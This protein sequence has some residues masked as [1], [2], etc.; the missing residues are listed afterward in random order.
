MEKE[1]RQIGVYVEDDVY[2]ESL[3]YIKKQ[4]RNRSGLLNM[5]LKEWV[6]KQKKREIKDG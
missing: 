5:L 4:G 2:Q 1:L 6:E 3:K